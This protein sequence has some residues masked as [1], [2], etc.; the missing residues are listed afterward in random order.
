[1]S[2]TTE[3]GFSIYGETK[4]AW[5]NTVRVQE[6]SISGDH[7]Q[8]G[9][10]A[11][12]FAKNKQGRDVFEH[13]GQHH[14]VSPHLTPAQARI[15]AE[16]LLK[17]A[18]DESTHAAR[19]AELERGLVEALD[20]WEAWQRDSQEQAGVCTPPNPPYETDERVMHLRA[21]ADGKEVVV[22]EP[23]DYQTR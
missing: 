10:F 12:I 1:M 22:C 6:S 11:W 4:D 9:P 5:G 2:E 21:L 23:E 14:A 13:L 7:E 20:Q 8:P 19:I 15:V 18:G 16:A 3:R 17:F